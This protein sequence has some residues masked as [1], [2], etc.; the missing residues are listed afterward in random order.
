MSVQ[1]GVATLLLLGVTGCAPSSPPDEPAHAGRHQSPPAS[2]HHADGPAGHHGEHRSPG[3]RGG[4]GPLGHRFESA[5]QWAGHFDDPARDQWQRP[6]EVVRL[7]ALRPGMAV[8]DVG[9]GTG[10]FLPH[11]AS[12]VESAGTVIGIDIEP[13]MVRHMTERAKRE[14][15]LNVQA[16]LATTSNP[17]LPSASVDRILIVNTWHHIPERG[18]YAGRL[19]QALRPAGFVAVV[20][21]TVDS[22]RGPPRAH[23]LP[24]AKVAEELG[25]GG[26]VAEVVAESLPDQYVVLGRRP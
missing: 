24:S 14:S 25:A 20:D 23:R 1:H 11:L 13:D 5:D 18:A 9:A 19:R 6:E 22:K 7:L 10:Y 2:H 16:R 26:L 17:G 15:L 8:A 21:F 3:H 12:A 4:H